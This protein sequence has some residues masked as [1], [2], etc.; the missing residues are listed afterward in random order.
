[1]KKKIYYVLIALFSAVFLFCAV[2]V[3]TYFVEAAQHTKYYDN[4]AS[5]KNEASISRPIPTTRPSGIPD[6]STDTT[7]PSVQVQ[8]TMLE[9]MKILYEMNPHTVGWIQIDGTRVNYPVVQTPNEPQWRDYYLY[10]DFE[11][12]DDRHGS[13]YVRETCDVF[14][15][16]DNITIYGHNMADHSMFG[17]LFDYKYYSYY[18]EHKYIYF[19]TLYERHTYEIYAIFRTS[20]TLGE[21]FSYHLFSDALSQADFD[22]FVATCKDLSM[23]D[24]ALTPQYGDKLITLSTCDFHIN[25]GRLVVCAVRID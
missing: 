13:I 20:G 17:E 14:T 5:I 12:K 16:S 25:N 11:G 15:P 23:H 6:P 2:Q 8:P 22:N 18:Q 24:I 7:A 10:R 9:D 3:I 21:G 4:L 1:M 19:D